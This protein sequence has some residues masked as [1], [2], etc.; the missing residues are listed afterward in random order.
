MAD[1][2]EMP[3]FPLHTVLFPGMVLPLHIF[4]PR[5]KVMISECVRENKPFGVVLIR[6]GPEVGGTAKTYEVGMSAYITQMEQLK[7]DRMN[8]Q[9][10][11]YQRFKLHGLRQD[12]PFQIGL[13]EDI[14]ITGEDNPAVPAAVKKLAPLLEEYLEALRRV[15]ALGL[16]FDEIPS[17]GRALAY[18]AA[19]MLPLKSEEK[20]SLLEAPDLLTM[21]NQQLGF[22]RREMLFLKHMLIQDQS[23]QNASAFSTN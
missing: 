22:V 5:Y 10:V 13:V 9:A 4:E 3:L 2:R 18:L 23:P 6:E 16:K 12:R 1:I 8:I 15:S 17:D 19:I 7:D 20:Q 14:P 21:L 11:G